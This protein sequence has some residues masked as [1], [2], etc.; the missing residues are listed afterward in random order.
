MPPLDPLP[1]KIVDLGVVTITEAREAGITD[2]SRPDLERLGRDLLAVR[3][4]ELS[5]L[6]IAKAVCRALPKSWISCGTGGQARGLS[7]PRSVDLSQPHVSRL[8]PANLPR[9]KAVTGHRAPIH[10]SEI[11]KVG[12]VFVSTPARVWLELA[13]CL[14]VRELIEFGD[15]L[16]RVPRYQHEG[17]STPHATIAELERLVGWHGRITGADR[18]AAAVKRIRVGADSIQ[19][20]RVR[21]ALVDAGLP[22]PQ[23]QVVLD[24][25][26]PHSPVSDLGYPDARLAID[27][28]G[29]THLTPEQQ[30]RDIRRDRTY[31]LAGWRHITLNRRDAHEGFRTCVDQVRTLLARP[32]AG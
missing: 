27:Y 19:E 8:R 3:D 11:T 10:K 9:M 18:A 2:L 22:E 29:G 20:T 26:D 5:P 23:L 24:P 32:W 15:H 31:A 4:V 12:A 17:R 21:L 16:V 25:S 14:T 6:M 13:S 30:A 28:D 7:V 1:A